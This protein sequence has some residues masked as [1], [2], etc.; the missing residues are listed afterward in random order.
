MWGK[1]CVQLEIMLCGISWVLMPSKLL[2]LPAL[3]WVIYQLLCLEAEMVV[4]DFCLVGESYPKLLQRSRS[5]NMKML[6]YWHQ[7]SW[8]SP[9]NQPV[10]PV[11]FPTLSRS[12][13]HFPLHSSVNSCLHMPKTKSRRQT[14]E[15]K[16]HCFLRSNN[17]KVFIHFWPI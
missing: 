7:F 17:G 2:Q 16:I 1:V 10:S 4:M 15:Q 14:G 11:F 13:I 5:T 8:S 6:M 12:G 9:Q 3:G